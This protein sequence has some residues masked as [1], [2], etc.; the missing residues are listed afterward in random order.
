VRALIDAGA[1]LKV[2]LAGGVSPYKMAKMSRCSENA[3]MLKEAGA[4]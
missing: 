3:K 2:K 4:K 1:D